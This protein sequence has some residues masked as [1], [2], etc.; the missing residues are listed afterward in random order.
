MSEAG[1]LIYITVGEPSGDQLASHLVR[2]LRE[3]TG[4]AVRFA[5]LAGE[6][7]RA[8]GL[9]SL[10]P[11]GELALMGLEVVPKLPRLL[12]RLS[13]TAADIRLRKPDALVMVDAQT[14]SQKIGEKLK[15]AP[16]P[17]LQY[18]APT[19]WA[20]KPGRAEKVAR[21]LTRLLSIFPF[22][23]PYFEKHGLP[24]SFVGHPAAEAAGVPADGAA[25]RARLGLSGGDPL[26]P[27]LCSR[28]LWRCPH[29]PRA[30]RSAT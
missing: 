5:G 11:I 19:V 13:E 3:A 12:R 26:P 8:E 2:A 25:L 28:A 18:V 27:W 24:V 21:Y 23:A 10:F 15:G 7:M 6:R 29:R 30:G 1:P 9:S 16:F 4:G 17:I 20:W 22:E 14:F